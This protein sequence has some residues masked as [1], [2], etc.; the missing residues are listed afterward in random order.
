MFY[1]RIFSTSEK[2]EDGEESGRG[3]RKEKGYGGRER[4]KG[5]HIKRLNTGRKR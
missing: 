3:K 2:E 5:S 1:E 4:G